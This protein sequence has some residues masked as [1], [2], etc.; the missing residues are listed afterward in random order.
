M[1]IGDILYNVLGGD[2]Y[3]YE[4][5]S[6]EYTEPPKYRFAVIN[7]GRNFCDSMDKVKLED[8]SDTPLAAI[9]RGLS[10][11]YDVEDTLRADIQN[12]LLLE[13]KYK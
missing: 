7:M 4:V 2:L 9:E 5:V 13:E 6:I 10:F 3:S 1:K 12:L 11:L 8:L